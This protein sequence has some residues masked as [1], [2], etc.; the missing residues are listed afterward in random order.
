MKIQILILKIMIDLSS[1]I[2]WGMR[3]FMDKVNAL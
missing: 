2:Q 3:D 1:Y